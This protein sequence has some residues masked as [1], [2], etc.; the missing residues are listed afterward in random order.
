MSYS[1]LTDVAALLMSISVARRWRGISNNNYFIFVIAPIM[2]DGAQYSTHIFRLSSIS[3]RDDI[4]S[5][6]GDS[7]FAVGAG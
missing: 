7:T 6:D 3:C 5:A 4:I 2:S 1:R